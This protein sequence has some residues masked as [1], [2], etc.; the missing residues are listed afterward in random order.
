MFLYAPNV[1]RFY[2]QLE[3]DVRC[4]NG[5]VLSIERFLNGLATHR[6]PWTIV[7]FSTLG[8]I[9]KLLHSSDLRTFAQFLLLFYQEQPV[10]YL[11]RAFR[12]AVAQHQVLMCRPTLFQHVGLKSTLRLTA[13]DKD[14][15]L[16]DK[17]FDDGLFHNPRAVVV[18]SMKIRGNPP[19]RVYDMANGTSFVAEN[20]HHGSTVDVTFNE[21]V[22][23]RRIVVVTGS[24][25]FPALFLHSGVLEAHIKPSD[26]T[27]D[28]SCAIHMRLRSFTD[29][30]VDV[31]VP[32]FVSPICSLHVRVMKDHETDVVFSQIAVFKA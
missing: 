14:N 24:S 8:F 1:S 25:H 13:E 17:Y 11:L 22:R 29:G 9:G 10:D 6:R 15:T 30:V 19:Q 12:V 20:P 26:K 2:I 31:I 32:P 23:L 16:K 3:D 18:S 27:E 5:F 7:D 4:A 28:A 21:P